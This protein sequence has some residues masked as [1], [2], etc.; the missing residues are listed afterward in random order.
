MSDSYD[1][2][3]SDRVRWYNIYSEPEH[4]CVGKVQLFLSYT[5]TSGEVD[6]AKVKIALT[7]LLFKRISVSVI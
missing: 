5:V 3:Q 7:L 2:V 4:E 6:S 1:D